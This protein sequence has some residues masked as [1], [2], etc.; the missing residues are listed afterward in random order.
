MATLKLNMEKSCKRA[1]KII[2]I[3]EFTKNEIDRFLAL[4]K[5]YCSNAAREFLSSDAGRIKTIGI[6]LKNSE[7]PINDLASTGSVIT[8]QKLTKAFI[9]KELKLIE[10]KDIE[11]PKLKEE[12]TKELTID[13]FIDD[14]KL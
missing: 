4:V 11:L 5:F 7:I 8:K 9:S 13:D 14:F 3:S 10:D 2:A 1:D 12:S 6:T